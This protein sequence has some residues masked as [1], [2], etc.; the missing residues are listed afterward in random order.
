MRRQSQCTA[1]Y[2]S[3]QPITMCKHGPVRSDIIQHRNF[4]NLSFQDQEG[5]KNCVNLSALI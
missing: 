4:K 2:A 3:T 1:L 5:H